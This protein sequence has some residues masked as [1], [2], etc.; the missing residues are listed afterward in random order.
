ME[1][2]GH[3]R[4]KKQTWTGWVDGTDNIFSGWEM[5]WGL[6][7][8]LIIMLWGAVNNHSGVGEIHVMT[9]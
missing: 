5:M 8:D 4:I 9:R 7:M 2:S 1:R 6:D 3:I